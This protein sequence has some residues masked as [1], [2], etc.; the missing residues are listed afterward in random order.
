MG[1]LK[2][3]ALGAALAALACA[4][5]PTIDNGTYYCGPERLC[6]PDQVCDDSSYTC[7]SPYDAEAFSCPDG[8]DAAE[9][10]D[11]LSQAR[12]VGSLSCGAAALEA[13]TGC[14][15]DIND[16]DYYVFEHQADCTGSD[17]HL[18][19]TLRYPVALVPLTVELLDEEENVVAE[20]ELCTPSGDLT[21]T[22][23][24]CLEATPPPGTY[25]VRVSSPKDAPDCD[26]ACHYNQY[27][28]A[29]RFPLS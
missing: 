5:S 17:P 2:E 20:G 12:D 27:T 13:A 26:G 23:K 9:P 15:P 1:V 11:I 28:I 24:L 22:D 25:Y 3:I 18:E 21:G 29:I 4:C 10:D 14:I 8:S 19:V 7:M 6:P 16:V